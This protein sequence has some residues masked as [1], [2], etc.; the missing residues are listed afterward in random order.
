MLRLFSNVLHVGRTGADVFRRDVGPAK[1]FDE[2]TVRA[3]DCF[4]IDRP[5]VLQND[6]LATTKWHAGES[7]LV[8]HATREPQHV[9]NRFLFILVLPETRTT[10]CWTKVR[11]VNRY[12]SVVIPIDARHEALV[13]LP[14]D[15]QFSD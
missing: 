12:Q 3:K 14:G 10:D 7:I 9:V 8:S 1:R 13:L 5:L 15:R 6:R 11:V 4:P 2:P